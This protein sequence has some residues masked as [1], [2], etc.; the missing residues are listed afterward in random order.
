[1]SSLNGY[2]SLTRSYRRE[3]TQNTSSHIISIVSVLPGLDLHFSFLRIKK[4][5][6]EN[7]VRGGDRVWTGVQSQS[8]H[9]DDSTHGCETPSLE[10]VLSLAMNKDFRNT[11]FDVVK[12]DEA[13]GS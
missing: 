7:L 12:L 8:R 1:M 10:S 11:R 9:H 13:D 4:L 2:R 6:C 3:R 5:T